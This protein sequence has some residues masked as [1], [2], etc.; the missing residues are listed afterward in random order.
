MFAVFLACCVP[1]VCALGQK[2]AAPGANFVKNHPSFS[3]CFPDWRSYEAA[4]SCHVF[5]TKKRS[6]LADFVREM[7]ETCDFLNPRL[8]SST[9]LQNIHHCWNAVA[10]TLYD[11]VPEDDMTDLLMELAL[12]CVPCPVALCTVFLQAEDVCVSFP[13]VPHLE[14]PEGESW[15]FDT[16]S[17]K[18]TVQRLFCIMAGSVVTSGISKSRKP[19]AKA[20]ASAAKK[21]PKAKAAAATATAERAAATPNLPQED[22]LQSSTVCVSRGVRNKLWADDALRA[23]SHVVKSV[24]S[25]ACFRS[26]CGEEFARAKRYVL[27]LSLTFAF[28]GEVLLP[29]LKGGKVHRRWSTLRPALQMLAVQHLAQAGDLFQYTPGC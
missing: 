4:R 13:K 20:K 5:A 7:Q 18:A 15:I 19:K 3:E 22:E 29:T 26:L 23:C 17:K 1:V 25:M 2:H 11:G 10:T 12:L 24:K 6:L 9:V 8:S 21:R 16:V 14:D 28:K 27:R